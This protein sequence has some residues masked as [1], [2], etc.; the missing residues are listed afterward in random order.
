[1]KIIEFKINRKEK[2]LEK[3]DVVLRKIID[4]LHVNKQLKSIKSSD[5]YVIYLELLKLKNVKN[6]N[7]NE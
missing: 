7:C 1:M 5:L 4:Y 6:M 3:E 2:T